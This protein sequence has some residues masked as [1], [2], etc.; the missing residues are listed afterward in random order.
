MQVY[1]YKAVRADGT[2]VEGTMQAARAE[3][4]RAALAGRDL[5]V[6]GVERAGARWYTKLL[7]E[8]HVKAQEIVLCCRQLATFVGVGIPVTVALHTIGEEAASKQLSAACSAM[9]GDIQ[10]GLRLS[11]AFR[12]HPLV[13]PQ[14]VSD[15]VLAS[16]ASGNLEGVLRQVANSI[17]REAS[18]KQKVQSAMVYPAII[19]SLAIVLTTAL[20]TFVLPQFR[21]LYSELGVPLPAVVSALLDISDFITGN[22]IVIVLVLL[23]AVIGFLWWMRRPSGRLALHRLFLRLPFTAP[24]VRASIV[25]RFCRTL[26]D[27]LAAG[28]PI[29]QTFSIVIETTSNLV[30]R[31]A[32][33]HV[34]VRMR[35]GSGISEPLAQTELFP[36]VVIQMVRVGEE[37]GRLDQHLSEMS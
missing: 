17:E 3:D 4:V 34:M 26:S 20:V 37:T 15:M 7:P 29:T 12:A 16:E 28:V 2:A 23:A 36:P 9:I 13:F 32:L 19:C 1:R 21:S 25:E 35:S 18:A 8:R 30:Y 22:A 5:R 10:R 27:L 31:S 11:D 33:Q 6:A 14:I 24:M